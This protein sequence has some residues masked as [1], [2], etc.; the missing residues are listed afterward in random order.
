MPVQ[1]RSMARSAAKSLIYKQLEADILRKDRA[2]TKLKQLLEN[3]S[4][5]KSTIE[6]IAYTFPV[7][8]FWLS[9]DGANLIQN[10][11][12]LR[13]TL[14]LKIQEFFQIGGVPIELALL[15]CRVY[16]KYFA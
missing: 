7:M 15:L 9:D 12:A 8:E 11:P 14:Q 2:I 1:T 5:T 13:S 10:Y 4:R 3:Q 16:T 6:R